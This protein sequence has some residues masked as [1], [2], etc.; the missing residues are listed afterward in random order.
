M[1]ILTEQT[2]YV[3]MLAPSADR[4]N[5]DPVS[6]IVSLENYNHFTGYI[7]CGASTADVD[8]TITVQ[9]QTSSTGAGA[10]NIDFR[11][12]LRASA[13]TWGTLTAAT[14]AG[15]D[16]STATTGG[17]TLAVEV[18]AAELAA[19]YSWLSLTVTESTDSVA[20]PASIHAIL[21][22][23]RFAGETPLTALS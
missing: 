23:P 2:N 4:F 17:W 11:Y 14:T 12:R 18:D 16:P 21:S 7:D 3:Q 13:D 19:G 9:E 22:E 8:L 10:R 20:V 1:S 5:G 15:V 6:D